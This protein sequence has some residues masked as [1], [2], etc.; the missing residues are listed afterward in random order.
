VTTLA[1]QVGLIARR[2]VRRTFRQPGVVIPP[3]TF[4]LFL[5]L[6][7]SNGLRAATRLPGFPTHSFL[8]FFLPFSFMQGCR[9]K[10]FFLPL[11][12]FLAP[13]YVPLHL[14]RGW[15]HTVAKVNPLTFLLTA[16]RGFLAGQPEDVAQAVAVAVALGVVF[17]LW[18]LRG[19]RI[20]ERAG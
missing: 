1:R 8:S 6:V 14:L 12:L 3:L 4:P 17:L 16:G 18:A 7:N 13:V 20:A 10:S 11:I 5:M 2:S 9:R 15:I 19:L